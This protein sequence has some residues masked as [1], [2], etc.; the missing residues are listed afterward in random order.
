VGPNNDA[1]CRF[2]EERFIDS[3]V[4]EARPHFTLLSVFAPALETDENVK[5]VVSLA[6]HVQVAP[7]GETEHN[8]QVQKYHGD[9]GHLRC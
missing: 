1:T 5:P 7:S 6:T 8:G 3:V 2:Q 4:K 9:E